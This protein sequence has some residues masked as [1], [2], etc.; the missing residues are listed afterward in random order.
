MDLNG[1]RQFSTFSL[2]RVPLF[3]TSVSL[4]W[5]EEGIPEAVAAF[6][7]Q[8]FSIGHLGDSGLAAEVR[9]P[10][11]TALSRLPE[12]TFYRADLRAESFSRLGAALMS[13]DARMG[14]V[15]ERRKKIDAGIIWAVP[16]S[17]E[18]WSV[19]I[20]GEAGILR[21]TTS[22]DHWYPEDPPDADGPVVLSS[23]RFRQFSSREIS[24]LT[25][26]FSGAVNFRP[27]WLCALSSNYSGGPWRLRGR[28]VYSSEYFRNADGEPLEFP[29]GMGLDW[30]YRPAAGLQFTL[31]YE[32]GWGRGYSDKGSVALGWRFGDLQISVESDWRRVFF[33]ASEEIAPCSGIKGILTWDRNF[34]HLGFTSRIE[35]G[36]DWYF[37]LSASFPASDRRWRLEPSAELHSPGTLLLL[38]L[39]LRYLLKIGHHKLILT[40]YTADLGK[41]WKP[42]TLNAGD[43]D[44]EIRWIQ[45]FD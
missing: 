12:K 27:G 31:D 6:N 25:M 38:D 16:V 34:F 23:F 14:T 3:S 10:D 41:G 40:L 9:N 39:R 20:L 26:I 1:D 18:R 19:E 8:G 33:S 5:T 22:D 28:A 37:R 32:A 17:T 43:S 36:E 7:G 11:F 4:S 44:L 30:R 35:P 2:L 21:E 29:I 24:G 45:S 42:E 15:W 13:A